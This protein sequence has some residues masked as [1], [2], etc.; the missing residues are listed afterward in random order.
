M[1]ESKKPP[2]GVRPSYIAI[3]YRIQELSE[4]IIRHKYDTSGKLLDEWAYEIAQLSKVE[5][6][7]ENYRKDNGKEHHMYVNQEHPDCS[8]IDIEETIRKLDKLADVLQGYDKTKPVLGFAPFDLMR[9]CIS[10]IT[11]IKLRYK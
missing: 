8:S 3:P 9:T 7:M 11:L 6:N 2:L 10:A 4:A 5:A 1:M